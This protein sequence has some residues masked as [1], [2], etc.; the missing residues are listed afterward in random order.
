MISAVGVNS[1][2]PS[3]PNRANP[4]VLAFRC[5]LWVMPSFVAITA[6]L[7]IDRF[8]VPIPLEFPLAF[9]LVFILG[10]GG[11]DT[12]LAGHHRN[13]S[14]QIAFGVLRFT[15]MQFF[16]LPVLIFPIWM[17]LDRGGLFGL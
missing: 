1:Q 14:G 9:N 13:E 11:F 6:A 8:R 16:L 15:C 4:A 7:L 10:I 12:L 17:I 5:C 3:F 2:T